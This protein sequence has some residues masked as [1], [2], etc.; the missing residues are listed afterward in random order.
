MLILLSCA[1]PLG[2]RLQS[3]VPGFPASGPLLLLC[4]LSVPFVSPKVGKT[5]K[6]IQPYTWMFPEAWSGLG[7]GWW[8]ILF[9]LQA[10]VSHFTG[11]TT[12]AQAVEISLSKAI[13]LLTETRTPVSDA[14]APASAMTAVPFRV[15]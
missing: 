2:S 9:P 11:Q 4:P 14:P 6:M 12:E 1:S 8:L 3:I 15:L 13:E 5:W 7:G 10:L